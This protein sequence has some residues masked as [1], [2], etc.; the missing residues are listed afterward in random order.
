MSSKRYI[1]YDVWIGIVLIVVCSTLFVYTLRFSGQTG[2][3][4]R[5]ALGALII[6]GAY[7]IYNGIKETK[8]DRNIL[9]SGGTVTPDLTLK[10]LKLPSVG[11]AF[12]LVYII[13]I[14]P[15]GFFVSTTVFMLVY[16]WFLKIRKP[17]VMILVTLGVD[18]FLYML[19]VFYLKLQLPEGILM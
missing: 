12:M 5:F 1:H 18:V 9:N 8:R 4:P 13:A 10:D 11:Y 7:T 6:L 19:F 3:F 2:I 15:V 16:M 17:A 14:E